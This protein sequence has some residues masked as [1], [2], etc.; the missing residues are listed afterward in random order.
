LI[1]IPALYKGGNININASESVEVIGAGFEKLQENIIIPAFDGNENSLTLD[2]FETG[3][4]TASEGVGDSGNILIQ[5]PNFKASDGGLV[6][7]IPSE[8]SDIKN[9]RQTLQDEVVLQDLRNTASSP[10]TIKEATGWI[11][12]KDG[13]IEFVTDNQQFQTVS[14]NCQRVR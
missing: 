8:N 14:E 7:A 11:V 10:S 13:D 3:I 6:V 2:N 12:D 4:A 1:S 9:P 5:T